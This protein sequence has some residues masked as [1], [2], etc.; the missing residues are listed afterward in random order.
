M[1]YL[2]ATPIGNLDDITLRALGVLKSVDLI[3]AE[4]TRRTGV[5]L[6]HHEIFGKGG[7]TPPLRSFHDHSGP[8]RLSEITGLLKEGKRVALVTDGGTPL[9][10][11]PGFPLLRE[12]V[13]QGI[14]VEVLPGASAVTTALV[15]S[16]LPAERFSFFGFLPAN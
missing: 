4:D 8:G 3:V 1:L 13:R 7:A 12:A 16:G 6:K 2:I 5:L 14:P 11:D 9:I 15:V 10:S